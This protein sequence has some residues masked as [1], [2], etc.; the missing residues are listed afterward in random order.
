M[1]QNGALGEQFAAAYLKK[2]GYCIL[3][4]N[5]NTRFGEIDII[6][7]RDDILAFVEVK[8]R[9]ANM[10]AT[11]ATAVTPTKQKKLIKAA[12]QYLQMHPNDLQPRFDVVSIVTASK[13]GFAVMDITHLAD[14]FD[15][16][17]PQF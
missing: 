1:T 17:T 16:T 14:A 12:L 4:T 2:Q 10:L 13:D 8:T 5:F 3:D 15:A 7:Q 9:A 6:A 11:P